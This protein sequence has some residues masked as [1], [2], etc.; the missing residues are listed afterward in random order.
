MKCNVANF[1]PSHRSVQG[2][3]LL[4]LV[5]YFNVLHVS[6][7]RNKL[8][9]KTLLQEENVIFLFFFHAS[10]TRN[11]QRFAEI[12]RTIEMTKVIICR[13][14]TSPSSPRSLGRK[15]IF[16]VAICA[17]NGGR[18]SS[19][20]MSR[21]HSESDEFPPHCSI[22][23][24][25]RTSQKGLEFRSN[26]ASPRRYY[27]DVSLFRLFEHKSTMRRCTID[28]RQLLSL[29]IMTIIIPSARG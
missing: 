2:T 15:M 5:F 17:T 16:S 14:T 3:S 19:E 18:R 21:E 10:M 4:L 24:E 6:A 12:R 11:T 20:L 28:T 29:P 13:L 26:V 27:M 23:A 1:M 22:L 25:G 9:I 8:M 7:A